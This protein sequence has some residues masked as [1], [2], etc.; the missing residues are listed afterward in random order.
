MTHSGGYYFPIF[1]KSTIQATE[2]QLQREPFTKTM[3]IS[4]WVPMEDCGMV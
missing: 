3:D 1:Y 2:E 4:V